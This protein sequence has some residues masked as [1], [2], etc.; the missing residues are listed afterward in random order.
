MQKWHF[1]GF[2]LLFASTEIDLI[3][4]FICIF[5]SNEIFKLNT[6]RSMHVR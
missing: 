2:D 3:R 4:V 6:T 5:I 1:F